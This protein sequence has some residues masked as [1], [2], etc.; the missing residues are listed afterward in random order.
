MAPKAMYRDFQYVIPFI[1]QIWMFASPVVYSASM[2]PADYRLLYGLNP[3][4]GVIEGFRWTLLGSNAPGAVVVVSAA[5]AVA[6][7]I[8]G[9]MYFRRM[10]RVFADE[11]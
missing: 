5:I 4:T 7:L 11:V 9:A 10:Q 2:I 6:I 8:S 3:M 1:V